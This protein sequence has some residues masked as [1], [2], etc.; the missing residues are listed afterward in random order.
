MRWEDLAYN[1]QPTDERDLTYQP[2]APDES[3]NITRKQVELD[4]DPT[5]DMLGCLNS[6]INWIRSALGRTHPRRKANLPMTASEAES[7]AGSGTGAGVSTGVSMGNEDWHKGGRV[8]VHCEKGISRSGA[9]VVA[10][11]MQALL[12]PYQRALSLAQASRPQIFPNIGFEWQLR[13][14]EGCAYDVFIRTTVDG[15]VIITRKPSYEQLV[16]TLER[17]HDRQDAVDIL[18]AKEDYLRNLAQMLSVLR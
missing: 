3:D 13:L 15:Q 8:L 17:I 16:D 12:V 9:V 6:M 2:Q 18:R 4:D 1:S 10:F 11:I 14:W 7:E 5:E